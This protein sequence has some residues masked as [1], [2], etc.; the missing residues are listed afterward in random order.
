MP[1]RLA[2]LVGL[3]A[4]LASPGETR[5]EGRD[6]NE[7]P[8]GAADDQALW[9][10]IRSGSDQAVIHLGRLSQAS[11]RIRYGR[12][13]ESLDAAE[14]QGAPA[15]AERARALRKALVAASE[16]ARKASEPRRPGVRE[17][18]YVLVDLEIKMEETSDPAVARELPAV[19][20]QGRA[21]ARSLE[22]IAAAAGP[23]ADALEKAL[24][25][26]D[27]AIRRVP[28]APP[29]ASPPEGAKPAPK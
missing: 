17:C 18:R 15:E 16:E 22:A 2:L 4:L 26:I 24:A 29:A 10:A 5:A 1:S 27:T 9:R 20:E 12:Y 19:R 14:A 28:P 13:Y 23:A 25:A 8:P 3:A 11:Y 6:Y 21:C 7:P